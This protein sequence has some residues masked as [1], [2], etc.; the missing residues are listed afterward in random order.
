MKVYKISRN[1]LCICGS[2]EKYKKC[3]MFQ[4]EE[5]TKKINEAVK[6]LD[7]TSAKNDIVETL[8]FVCGLKTR[9]EGEKI[10]DAGLLGKLLAEVWQTEI[11]VIKK[12]DLLR[13]VFQR[14]SKDFQDILGTKRFL[15]GL[16]IPAK[17]LQEADPDNSESKEAWAEKVLKQINELSAELVPRTVEAMAFSLHHEEYNEEE[18][19]ALLLGLSWVVGDDTKEFFFLSLLE[20]TEEDLYLAQQEMQ[21]ILQEEDEEDQYSKLNQL[22]QRYPVYDD[23]LSNN[24]LTKV[25]P[26]YEAI[27]K[28]E[29][30]L[31]MP[32]YSFIEG[33]Y[34]LISWVGDGVARLMAEKQQEEQAAEGT[35][36]CDKCNLK[37]LEKEVS[38]TVNMNEL[39]K[40]LFD[41]IFWQEEVTYFVPALVTALEKVKDK[42]EGELADSVKHLISSLTMIV[43][44]A[45]MNVAE[46]LYLF[47]VSLFLNNVPGRFPDTGWP[48]EK[49]ASLMDEEL[50]NHYCNY[51]EEQEMNDEAAYVREKHAEWVEKA[52][53]G[54]AKTNDFLV[55]LTN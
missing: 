51:L 27:T 47:F 7:Y 45:Q 32:F 21:R 2:G 28:K 33:F 3:C 41:E 52:K 42:V 14:F 55:T 1:D 11:A 18:L 36:S 17:I 8:G 24:I 4:V 20:K 19:K 31:E 50:I 43:C 25:A 38:S 6:E 48:I 12:G 9:I 49:V 30:E 46:Y 54:F 53:E 10:P 35:C 13:D 34:A 5:A 15:R 37:N 23:M 44:A 26:A 39:H 40:R 16:R 22:M 29:L